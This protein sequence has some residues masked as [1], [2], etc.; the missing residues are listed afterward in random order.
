M[1]R[2]N[3]AIIF[4]GCSPEYEVSLNSV[5]SVIEHVN[6]DLYNTIL[7]GITKEGEWLRYFGDV[8]KIRNNTW[9]Q[10]KGCNPVAFSQSRSIHGFYEFS[11]GS[12]SITFVDAAFPILHGRNGEDGTVQGML[13]LAGIPFVGCGILSSAMCMDK[14]IAHRIAQSS[15]IRVPI[16]ISADKNMI[17]KDILIMAETLRY[18]VFVK[19]ARAG[20]SFGITR[21]NSRSELEKAII[22]AF[23]YDSKI[24]VEENIDGFEV[25]CAILGNDDLIIG[26]VDEIELQTGF[27]DYNEKYT[28][29][30][31]KI[32][33]PARI[34]K[35]TSERVKNTA[36]ILYNALYCTG[37]ARV[38]MFLTPKGEIVFNEVNTIPG[39]TAHSRYPNMLRGAGLS[40]AS[41]VDRLIR[42]AMEK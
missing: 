29:K 13:K 40:F 24:V 15:G 17:L 26:E 1:D 21:A 33:M 2:K 12:S 18:P 27:F 41:I 32:H 23:E 31:S 9:F 5:S 39:F 14:D 25:G 19:P 34:D 42:M 28:L 35:V 36:R 11:E 22:N 10:E 37:F 30:T 16:S 20:S 4:G 38:D 8:D 6:N 3:I 7:I